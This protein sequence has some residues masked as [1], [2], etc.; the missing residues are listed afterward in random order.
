VF[1]MEVLRQSISDVLCVINWVKSRGASSVGMFG[2]SYGSLLCGIIG[3]VEPSI[4]F[5]IMVVPPA[6][7]SE[8]FLHSRLGRLFEREN[9]NAR[10]MMEE[11]RF[12]LDRIALVNLT[13]LVPVNRIFIAEAKYDGMVPV[14]VV[15]KLWRAWG[16]PTI[17]RYPHGHLSVIIFNPRLDRDM[18]RWLQAI[19]GKK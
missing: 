11:Y 1:T 3:C 7:M 2:V 17:K 12:M 18:H 6:D 10:K 16:R 14:P 13:P 5:L 8:V 19:Q 4:D 15:E 9:P